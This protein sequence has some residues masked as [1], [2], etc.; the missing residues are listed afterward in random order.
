MFAH[1]RN[2]GQLYIQVLLF[3]VIDVV[4]GTIV[5][6]SFRLLVFPVQSPVQ[7][8]MIKSYGARFSPSYVPA[9]MSNN[10][11][12]PSVDQTFA[13]VS[14][15]ITSTTR[16]SISVIPYARIILISLPSMYGIEDLFKTSM[17][18]MMAE[19][20]LT[21]YRWASNS[22]RC[23]TLESFN[24]W[25]KTFIILI[26]VLYIIATKELRLITM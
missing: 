22:T 23:Y 12:S 24:S 26:T 5:V 11:V 9:P 10:S 13:F 25:E 2:P 20:L 6:N 15:F 4:F 21:N 17:K 7:S 14:V 16:T 19:R 1:R 18:I 3:A 8:P